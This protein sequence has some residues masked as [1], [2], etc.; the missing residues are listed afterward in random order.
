MT[1][2]Y[3]NERGV[4]ILGALDATAKR[5][6]ATPAQVALAWNIA[7]PGI[8]SPIASATSLGQLQDLVAASELRLDRE[9]LQALDDASA[10]R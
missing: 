1:A 3:L 8:T 10:W 6:G 5:L 7:Q 9:A 2:K 4:R